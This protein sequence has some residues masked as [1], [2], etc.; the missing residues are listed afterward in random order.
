MPLKDPCQKQ[1]CAIQKC[2][3]ANNYIESR[4][5]DVIRAMRKCCE[6]HTGK[7]SVCC[8]GFT[9]EHKNTEDKSERTELPRT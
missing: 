8:T 3:Q 9:Q 7:N 1:A 2:L 5:E 6:V 4:C